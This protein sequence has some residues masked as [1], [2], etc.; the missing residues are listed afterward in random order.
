MVHHGQLA[1]VRATLGRVQFF[2]SCWKSEAGT[3]KPVLGRWEG[4]SPSCS[5]QGWKS[6]HMVWFII[7]RVVSPFGDPCWTDHPHESRQVS[8]GH[9]CHPC[10]RLRRWAP[11]SWCCPPACPHS[12]PA[13]GWC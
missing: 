11:G 12:P 1:D 13:P 10:P 6:G 4:Y 9:P 3:W 2:P 5:E 8:G 7:G